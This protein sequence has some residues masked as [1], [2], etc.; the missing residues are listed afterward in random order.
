MN[1]RKREEIAGHAA[2]LFRVEGY[3]GAS[4]RG[5][6]KVVGMEATSLYNHFPSKVEI[7]QEICFTVARKFQSF[8]NAVEES[9][10]TTMGRLEEVMRLL[11]RLKIEEFDQVYIFENES[12]YLNAPDLS[13]IAKTHKSLLDCLTVLIIDGIER[14]EMRSINP[15]VVV[16]SILAGINGIEHWH[17]SKLNINEQQLEDNMVNYLLAGIRR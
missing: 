13:L 7:L 5:L 17:R 8:I 14:K 2:R 16:A 6:G 1:K 4:M 15:D 11:V 12:R 10:K 9:Q 3:D